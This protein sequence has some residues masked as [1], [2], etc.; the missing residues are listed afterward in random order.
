MFLELSV[1]SCPIGPELHPSFDASSPP[2]RC[3]QSHEISLNKG[4]KYWRWALN[5]PGSRT[6]W[7]TVH[8]AA[9]VIGWMRWGKERT[10][11]TQFSTKL[12]YSVFK[13][14]PGTD[15][16]RAWVSCPV[17]GQC[18]FLFLFFE[19]CS[20]MWPNTGFR[21]RLCQTLR[22]TLLWAVALVPMHRET[23]NGLSMASLLL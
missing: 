20:P 3:P 4:M 21:C 17:K 10:V 2:G 1:N 5:A 23:W 13:L 19:I 11:Q 16:N 15:V 8:I 7:A 22:I 18:T 9:A 14:D 6:F 12:L